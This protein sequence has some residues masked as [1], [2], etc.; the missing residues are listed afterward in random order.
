MLE[1][2]R[3]AV[4]LARGVFAASRRER[5]R[6]ITKA[7]HDPVTEADHA[8]D[9]DAASCCAV[10]KVGCLRK[11]P[12]ISSRLN[13]ERVWVVDPLDGNARSSSR[14]FGSSALSIAM[15]E[16]GR[17]VAGADLQSCDERRFSGSLMQGWS[18]TAVRR[19][20]SQRNALEGAVVLA[21]RSEA[22]HGS[23]GSFRMRR[24]KF[25]DGI[26]WLTSWRESRP[27]WRTLRSL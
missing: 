11:P 1:R 16:Q 14:A 24:S 9:A 5:W 19:G 18:S 21:S 20:V 10:A 15:V 25:E 8:L 12:T 23:G 13:C 27:G 22:K 4:E 6:R 7:G 3:A 2:I 17:P 26:G